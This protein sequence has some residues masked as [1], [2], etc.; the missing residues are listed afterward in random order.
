VTRVESFGKKYY[1]TRVE[2]PS[3]PNVTRIESLT[4]VTLSL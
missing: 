2:S 1:S 4:R 3:F